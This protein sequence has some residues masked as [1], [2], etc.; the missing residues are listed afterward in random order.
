M[1]D[2]DSVLADMVQVAHEAGALTLQHFARFRDL[3]IGIKGP[4]GL[5]RR[6][7]DSR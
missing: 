6:A 3:E 1:T 7:V 2:Y 5:G 4:A